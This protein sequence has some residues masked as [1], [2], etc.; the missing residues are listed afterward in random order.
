MT[1]QTTYCI[2]LFKNIRE[3]CPPFIKRTTPILNIKI[4]K[5]LA[6]RYIGSCFFVYPMHV[7]TEIWSMTISIPIIIC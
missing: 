6:H 7:F 1:Q 2:R 5:L 3:E 4:K